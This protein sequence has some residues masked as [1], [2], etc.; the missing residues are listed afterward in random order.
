[1]RLAPPLLL[2]ASVVIA[3]SPAPADA[4]CMD[5][6]PFVAPPAGSSLPPHPEIY[7][8]HPWGEHGDRSPDP[9]LAVEDAAGAPVP[10]SVERASSSPAYDAFRIAIHRDV[11]GAITVRF[12]GDD[13]TF[14]IDP[15]WSTPVATGLALTATRYE[16][17]EW[18]C[19][20]EDSLRIVPSIDA[21][22]YRIDYEARVVDDA[23]RRQRSI[24]VPRHAS[25][26]FERVGREPA[27]SPEVALGQLNCMGANLELASAR[28]MRITALFADGSEVPG[29]DVAVL[30]LVARLRPA[31]PPPHPLELPYIAVDRLFRPGVDDPVVPD[32]A[33][34][35][36]ALG[37]V[38]GLGGMALRARRRAPRRR[39]P[40]GA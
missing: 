30:P 26:F 40:N 20:R 36:F 16:R 2:L 27:A 14:T 37:V 33:W 29:S 8:F 4:T 23:G 38:A 32:P 24:L 10:F 22:A 28:T 35:Y 5:P 12:G 25:R 6:A 13:A 17:L 18:A 19:S 21:P 1:M 7:V 11:P 31:E 34:P 9:V 3:L 15:A 39:D